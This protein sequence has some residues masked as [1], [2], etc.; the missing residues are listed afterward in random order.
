MH[1]GEAR[2]PMASD[3]RWHFVTGEGAQC[4]EGAT[5]NSGVCSLG[6][7]DDCGGRRRG[8]SGKAV[9]GSTGS[10]LQRRSGGTKVS[11]T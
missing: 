4:V 6:L 3:E 2:V 9:S 7:G 1:D 5:G 8:R 11:G 10:A